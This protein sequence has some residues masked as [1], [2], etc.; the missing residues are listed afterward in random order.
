MEHEVSLRLFVRSLLFVQDETREV[1]QDVAVVL[2]KKFDAEMDSISF[3]KRAFGVARMEMLSFRRDE[4]R[5]RHS[6][7]AEVYDVLAETI[8]EE[9]DELS[10]ERRALDDCLKKLQSRPRDLVRAAY[11]PWVRIGEKPKNYRLRVIAQC[12]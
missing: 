12:G 9:A 7:G 5:D 3:R 10:A 2:W 1:M 11:A 4:A 8:A 6:F